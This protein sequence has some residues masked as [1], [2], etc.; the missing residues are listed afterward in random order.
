VA[1]Q[2]RVL[3]KVPGI[4]GRCRAAG[5]GRLVLSSRTGLFLLPPGGAPQPFRERTGG[6]TAGGGEPYIAL[7]SGSRVWGVSGCSFGAGE[8]FALDAGPTPGIVRVLPGGQASR[9]FDFPSGAFPSGIAFDRFGR[10]RLPAARDRHL[11][12]QDDPVTPSTV[13]P[14]RL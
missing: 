1:S 12:R 5:D 13:S 10:F 7:A 6:Y 4:V 14:I 8:V 2:W 9:F 11:R 3:V